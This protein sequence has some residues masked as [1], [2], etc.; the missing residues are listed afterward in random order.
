MKQFKILQTDESFFI[1]MF[2]KGKV[3]LFIESF[4]P[5][6]DI[7]ALIDSTDLRDWEGYEEPQKEYIKLITSE[8]DY[9]V[10]ADEKWIYPRKMNREAQE[11]FNLDILTWDEYYGR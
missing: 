3:E 6:A 11:S 5:A 9:E 10:I 2:N 4:D 8:I 1:T 7:E